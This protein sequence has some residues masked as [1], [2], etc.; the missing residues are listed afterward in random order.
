M[1]KSNRL[2]LPAWLVFLSAIL[3]S[4][5]DAQEWPRQIDSRQETI[6]VYQ[7]QLERFENDLLTAR[8]AVSIER[9]TDVEPVFGA[10]WFEAQLD[11]ER[12]ERSVRLRNVRILQSRFPEASPSQAA[13]YEELINRQASGWDLDM[14]Y[15]QMLAALDADTRTAV[16]ATDLKND[17]PRVLYRQHPALL[18][19]INGEPR[20]RQIEGSGVMRVINSP[21]YI[22]F[23]PSLKSFY[24]KIGDSWFTSPDIGG[25]WRQVNQPPTAVL[26]VAAREDFPPVPPEVQSSLD[27]KPEIVVSL[28]PAELIVSD[29][30]PEYALLEG[31]ELLYLSNSDS[32]VFLDID[33][34]RYYVVLSGRWYRSQGLGGPW[35]YV[36]P[37]AL[38]GKFERIPAGSPKEHVLAHVPETDQAREAILD[39]TI[40]ETEKI[41]R[42]QTIEVEYDGT[43]Q[44]VRIDGTGMAYAVN[45]PYAVLRADGGYYACHEAVWYVAAG[46]YGPWRVAISVPE[47]IYTLPPSSPIYYVRYVYVYG[48]TPDIVYVGYTPGYLGTYIYSGTVVYGTGYHYRPWYRTYYYPRPLTWGFH[49]TYDTYYGWSFGIGLHGHYG[50]LWYSYGRGWWGPVHHRHH[51][52]HDIRRD[53]DRRVV[54]KRPGNIY[55]PISKERWRDHWRERSRETREVRSRA[56]ERRGD[57]DRLER[58]ADDGRS[59]RDRGRDVERFRRRQTNEQDVRERDR[60][61]RNDVYTDRQGRIY[62]RT[63]EGWEERRR[64]TW[65]PE[66]KIERKQDIKRPEKQLERDY[67]A[68]ER[69]RERDRQLYRSHQDDFSRDRGNSRRSLTFPDRKGRN[70]RD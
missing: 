36:R 51:Y 42:E 21:M 17:P 32:D 56:I 60:G 33:T 20:L 55:R 27:R 63:D 62:R 16:E 12:E 2:L 45:S 61:R 10:I 25:A 5:V 24:L 48:Y 52:Y 31:S 8:A 38:P 13:R 57:D 47:V 15:D 14:T 58:R 70:T 50:N 65:T 66:R 26:D 44:F 35:E 23:E 37:E 69:G 68:R 22:V 6:I 40:P 29:G 3:V 7:P 39:A 30:Q 43:P 28:E 46:P 49:V 67:K 1:K 34:Q 11:I 64:K 59:E 19:L 41:D 54:I 18:V 53:H 4:N 9:P